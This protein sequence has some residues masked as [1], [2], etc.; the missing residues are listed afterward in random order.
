M[1]GPAPAPRDERALAPLL[2]LAGLVL[3]PFLLLALFG[4]TPVPASDPRASDAQVE[5][6]PMPVPDLPATGDDTVVL[7]D[8]PAGDAQARNAGVA[9]AAIGPGSASPFAFRG[10][11]ADRLRARDCLALAGMAEAG[12]GDGDQRAVMQVILNRVRHPAFAGSV[13]GVVFEGSQRPTGCQFSFTCDGSLARRYSDAA[14]RAARARAEAMLGG[15]THAPVGN[16]THFHADY[17]YP[18]WSDRLD[19][20]A[21]VGPHIFFRWRGFWG[22]RQA[23]SARYTGGEPDP[24]RLRETA[25]ATAA[26]N[27]LP[28][29]LG[30]GEAVRSITRDSVAR[31]AGETPRAAASAGQPSRGAG[32]HFVLVSPGDS[33]G[34]LVDRARSLCA[35]GG[36]C[37]VQGWSDPAQVP[38]SLPLTDSDRRSLR[39]SFAAANANGGEAVFFDC[40]LFSAPDIGTCLPAIP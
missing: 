20:V 30:S 32:V 28:G 7:S 14:W 21:K 26:A 6:A 5:T 35:G 17:V 2:A 9:F 3:L 16:A 15:A 34:A 13:C 12:G 38:A 4:G 1:D 10:S 24:L 18:W 8:L 39:F 29:L 23:L 31:A 33:P 19:K 11:A 37:R 40:R 22:S 36:Y 27:P 25:L